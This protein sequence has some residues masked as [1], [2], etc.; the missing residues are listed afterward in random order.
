ME[1]VTLTPDPSPQVARGAS[2]QNRL[3]KYSGREVENQECKQILKRF[4]GI[5]S[6]VDV[7][8]QKVRNYFSVPRPSLRGEG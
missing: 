2:I 8:E 4:V 7:I 3:M 1:A 6:K 5:S